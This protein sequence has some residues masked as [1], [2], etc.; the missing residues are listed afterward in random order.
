MWLMKYAANGFMELRD[1][2]MN[3]WSS[4]LNLGEPERTGTWNGV[5]HNFLIYIVLLVWFIFNC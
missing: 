5:N 4:E 1:K 3:Y 2:R